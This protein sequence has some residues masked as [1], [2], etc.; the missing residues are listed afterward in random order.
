MIGREREAR[1]L[2]G[3]E[4]FRGAN[5]N[6][7]CLYDSQ[8]GVVMH[9]IGRKLMPG[10]VKAQAKLICTIDTC[11]NHVYMHILHIHMNM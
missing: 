1:A 7:E 4:V 5:E 8:W 3:R 11:H 10:V 9:M 2:I 6:T